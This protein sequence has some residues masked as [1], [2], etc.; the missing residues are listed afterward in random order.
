MA[1]PAQKDLVA[2][3]AD[4]GEMAMKAL[5]D[6][7]GADRVLAAMTTFRERLDDLQKRVRGLETLEQRLTELEQRVDKLAGSGSSSKSRKSSSTSGKPSSA[8]KSGTTEASN[9]GAADSGS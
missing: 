1:G 4:A 5:A 8:K 7:P 3:L 6:A 2:R 9:S